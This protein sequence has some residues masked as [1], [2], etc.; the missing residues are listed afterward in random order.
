MPDHVRSMFQDGP[1]MILTSKRRS[2]I[3]QTYPQY[4]HHNNQKPNWCGNE[5][6]PKDV[7]PCWSPSYQ[8]TMNFLTFEN[9][10]FIFCLTFEFFNDFVLKLFKWIL[11]GRKW[12]VFWKT[13]PSHLSKLDELSRNRSTWKLKFQKKMDEFSRERSKS[14]S[15]KLKFQKIFWCFPG[16]DWRY[17][18][19]EKLIQICFRFVRIGWDLRKINSRADKTDCR[20]L[21]LEPVSN[22]NIQI[23]FNIERTII[24]C[25]YIWIL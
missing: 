9:N 25:F 21:S 4:R 23:V 20:W 6:F 14:Q 2:S 17:L 10:F 18:F 15:D 19:V 12:T 13:H 3:G 5:W 24:H 11:R 7:F 16:F 8:L 1:Q 22:W